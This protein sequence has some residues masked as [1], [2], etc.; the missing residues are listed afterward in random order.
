MEAA[1]SSRQSSSPAGRW[2]PTHLLKCCKRKSS[3]R[4]PAQPPFSPAPADRLLLNSAVKG[5]TSGRRTS[6]RMTEPQGVPSGSSWTGHRQTKDTEFCT[7]GSDV[8]WYNSLV[9]RVLTFLC[10]LRPPYLICTPVRC[11]W[12]SSLSTS[13]G[14][15]LVLVLLP[16]F[17]WTGEQNRTK[18]WMRCSALQVKY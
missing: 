17:F 1:E 13:T 14:D 16:L 11:L 4:Q 5:G 8:S 2:W 6:G 7:L 3:R 18:R 10:F 9:P 12:D 15:P